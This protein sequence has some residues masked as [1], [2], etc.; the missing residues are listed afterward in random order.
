MRLDRRLLAYGVALPLTLMALAGVGVGLVFER[1]LLSAVDQSLRAQAA[2]ESVSLFDRPGAFPHLHADDS[3]VREA[4]LSTGSL[5][6]AAAAIYGPDGARLLA[7][8]V[9]PRM[10]E[11]LPPPAGDE[12]QLRTEQGAR[13]L[14]LRVPSPDGRPHALWLSTSLE[15]TER[16]IA[17]YWRSSGFGLLL[18][19]LALFVAQRRHAGWLA[20]RIEGIAQHVQALGEGQLDQDPPGDDLPDVVGELRAAVSRATVRMREDRAARERMLAG[21]AHELRTPLATLRA[22]V[23]VT[24]RR[25]RGDA[26]LREALEEVGAEVT[27]LE[28][29]AQELLGMGAAR[30]APRA[31]LPTDLR[32]LVRDS[33]R[34]FTDVA[35]LAEVTLVL[36]APDAV[37]AEV[38]PEML[39]RAV[40]NLLRNALQHTP[41]GTRVLVSLVASEG[42]ASV[43]V[44]DQG[45]GIPAGAEESVFVPFHREARAGEGAGLGLALVR[46]IAERH[47]GEARVV[48]SDE[49]AC[50]EIVVP[51]A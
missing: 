50:L 7:T 31:P 9:S 36:R 24:L 12:P 23:D 51:L 27:R 11:R 34:R 13:V 20:R 1:S 5:D 35:T 21:A 37:R 4:L 45:R 44:Q 32:E 41:R 17:T 39:G 16:A 10:P 22:T 2:A 3:P 18:V 47:G 19:A 15:P 43:R 29:M 33:I 30:A 46:A 42:R 28:T 48:P 25:P 38:E 14:V 26:E 6:A 40:D 49:G 8:R